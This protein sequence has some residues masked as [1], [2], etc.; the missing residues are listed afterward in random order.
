M[1]I[2]LIGKG[3]REHALAFKISRS[4]LL[5]KLYLWPGNP[6][7]SGLGEP[8]DLAPDALYLTKSLKQNLSRLIDIADQ[9]QVL[10]VVTGAG[11]SGKS[12]IAKWLSQELA[13]DSHEILPLSLVK[14]ESQ[15]GWLTPRVARYFGIDQM[16][17]WQNLMLATA[18]KFD[19]L[20]ENKRKLM[21]IIDAAHLINTPQ[22]FD[23]VVAYLNLQSI[24]GDCLSFVLIGREEVLGTV[25]EVDELKTK[26]A[27]HVHLNPLFK[28]ETAEYL[29][30]KAKLSGIEVDFDDSALTQIHEFSAGVPRVIDVLGENSLI[31]AAMRET[32]TITLDI[33]KTCIRH[34]GISNLPSLKEVGK[35][36]VTPN[37]V[38][39]TLKQPIPLAEL[40]RSHEVPAPPAKPKDSTE[41]QQHLEKKN[42]TPKK[43]KPSSSSISMNKLFKVDS[44]SKDS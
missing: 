22:A 18:E 8:L 32:K 31:E 23:E 43:A 6:A 16:D 26:L 27:C 12:T 21:I 34:A 10:S 44:D 2:L 9:T 3:G 20:F 29:Q 30:H 11:G 15:P 19:D 36:S 14:K 35:T 33:A 1:N 42:T 28:E 13:F 25:A 38:E 24:A 4:P 5:T 37:V 41:Q 7:M 40:T 17:T 39:K